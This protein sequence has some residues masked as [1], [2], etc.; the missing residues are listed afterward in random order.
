MGALPAGHAP[1]T[2]G[3]KT[4]WWYTPRGGYGYRIP[5]DVTVTKLGAKRI[6]VAAPLASGSLRLIWVSPESLERSGSSP[7]RTP[8]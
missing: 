6:Q 1:H 8:A 5:V 7:E 3:E 4:T 2:V